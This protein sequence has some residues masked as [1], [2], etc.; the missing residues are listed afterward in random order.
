[1]SIVLF[2]WGVSEPLKFMTQACTKSQSVS[3]NLYAKQERH[4]AIAAAA[5]AVLR[6]F[7]GTQDGAQP[8]TQ[9]AAGG[10]DTADIRVGSALRD[11]VH[12]VCEWRDATARQQDEGGNICAASSLWWQCFWHSIK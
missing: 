3:L 6:R 8:A 7:G 2:R 9:T 12:A 5:S 1:M 11:C 10:G 4:A